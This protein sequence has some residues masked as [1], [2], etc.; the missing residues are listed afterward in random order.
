MD[1]ELFGGQAQIE[2]KLFTFS[3]RENLKGCF[4]KI[5]EDV[6]GRR[7]TVIVPASGLPEVRNMIDKAWEICQEH[8]S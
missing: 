4:F 1:K 5:T 8:K 2:R 3:L 6:G 7:D